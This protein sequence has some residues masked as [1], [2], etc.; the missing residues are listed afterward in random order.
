[1]RTDTVLFSMV[2]SSIPQYDV[3][4]ALLATVCDVVVVVFWSY[5]GLG[6]GSERSKPG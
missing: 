4:V 2:A 5:P 1:M 3:A 6:C